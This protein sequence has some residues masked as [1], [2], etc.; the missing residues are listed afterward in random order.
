MMNIMTMPATL[1][2]ERERERE[3]E[4]EG[5]SKR[6]GK[7]TCFSPVI[8]IYIPFIYLVFQNVL[9][10]FCTRLHNLKPLFSACLSQVFGEHT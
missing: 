6:E 3:R 8:H 10:T 9:F 4:K 2:G 5:H 1:P 7:S